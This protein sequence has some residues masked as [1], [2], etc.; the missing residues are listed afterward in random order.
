MKVSYFSNSSTGAWR[1]DSPNGFGKEVYPDGGYYEGMFV[2]GQKQGEGV[3][4]FFNGEMYQG[5]FNHDTMHGKGIYVL[6]SLH[7]LV[8]A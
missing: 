1:H 7:Q 2:N 4:V 6:I 8:M 5:Q 3:L